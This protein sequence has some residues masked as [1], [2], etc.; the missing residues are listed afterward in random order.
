MHAFTVRG[1]QDELIK[2]AKLFT[3][4]AAEWDAM[5]HGSVANKTK[6]VLDTADRLDLERGA[7]PTQMK[8]VTRVARPKPGP[9]V[10]TG[11]HQA[12]SGLTQTHVRPAPAVGHASTPHP[13]VPG[14]MGK[15]VQRGGSLLRAHAAPLAIGAGATALGALALNRMRKKN[16]PPR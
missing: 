4:T 12:P 8:E 6:K 1:F 14:G 7:T 13:G 15:M 16:A 5:Q 2:I 10:A 3:G 11:V 9:P